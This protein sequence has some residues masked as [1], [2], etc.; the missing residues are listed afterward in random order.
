MSPDFELGLDEALVV[1][2]RPH[3]RA[4]P[5]V[6]PLGAAGIRGGR[7]AAYRKIVSLGGFAATATTSTSSNP[8]E[9]QSSSAR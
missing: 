8:Y 3:P 7:F 1:H 6:D 4:Q 5:L 2:E 9:T